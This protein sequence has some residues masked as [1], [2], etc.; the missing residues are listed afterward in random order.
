MAEHY[1]VET[2]G[3]IR[4]R[5]LLGTLSAVA[6][7][8][9]FL[10][11]SLAPLAPSASADP[12]EI[13]NGQGNHEMRWTYT[14]PSN[15]SLTNATI[16]GGHASLAWRDES[17]LEN[18]QAAYDQAAVKQNV[19]T[20]KFP[21]SVVLRSVQ[22]SLRTLTT[23]PGPAISRD[24]YISQENQN[25]NY[26]TDT[27]LLINS[28]TNKV[29]RP[30][31]VFDL[32]S[33]PSN[34]TIID[35]TLLLWVVGGQNPVIDFTIRALNHSYDEL[36]ADWRYASGG[37]PWVVYGGDF[38]TESY[39][40]GHMT[41]T[42]GWQKLGISA[43]V[44]LWIK[45]ELPNEG[46][47]LV[48]GL[49]G[50]SQ[51]KQITSSD[52]ALNPT[53]W[54]ML[55][56][57]YTM[58]SGPGYLES[59]AIGPGTNSQFTTANWTGSTKSLASDEFDGNSLNPRWKWMNDPYASGGSW[60]V[61]SS[62]PGWLRIVGSP[63]TYLRAG[64]DY[65]PNFIYENATGY[66]TA[67]T[68]VEEQFTVNSMGAGMCLMFDP[69]TWVAIVKLGAGNNGKIWATAS[70]YGVGAGN[71]QVSWSGMAAVYLRIDKVPAGIFLN[72]SS[73]GTLWNNLF[74]F[75]PAENQPGQ[76]MIGL[77]VHSAAPDVAVALYEYL[78]VSPFVDPTTLQVRARLG[79]STALSDPSWTAW[80][81]PLPPGG[82]S[83]NGQARYV[84]YSVSLGTEVDW[85]S[86]EFRGIEFHYGR[87][88]SSGT[89][90]MQEQTISDLRNWISIWT[91]EDY[92]SGSVTYSYSTDH[93]T[94]WTNLI[95]KQVN[96]VYSTSRY[97]MIQAYVQTYD[98]LSTPLLNLVNATYAIKAGDF[99]IIAPERVE[100]G[101]PFEITVIA[102]DDEKC[103][104]S[105]VRGRHP[106]RHGLNGLFASELGALAN[107]GPH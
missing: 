66:F 38:S 59:K 88:A 98:T 79:N 32:A 39:G 102:K 104:D 11:T 67:T 92:V 85:Y 34:A 33:I 100:A 45:G 40:Q 95:N 7:C 77:S 49:S 29:K 10:L 50:S 78:R 62:R 89:V 20:S 94:H 4:G 47:I 87:Y 1:L 41:N 57:N 5:R 60:D 51:E 63:Y 71:A 14:N 81:A 72:Y 76:V 61:N 13:V 99:Y 96:P 22:G 84:Q 53:H 93:G 97:M 101:A 107:L 80:S 86:P 74:V 48:P 106:K 16:S 15:Y 3:L 17:L 37:N 43:L 23:Q 2:A 44:D 90:A 52:D 105:V 27:L 75:S 73:D 35:A 70:E 58:P 6:I 12:I 54:P 91:S 30:L 82:A 26:G 24:T 18:T 83:I 56:V 19:D 42:V 25:N 21:G 65:L 68:H 69:Q 55:K 28:Q 8:G 46:L 36:T 31:I 9:I 103:D 64:L